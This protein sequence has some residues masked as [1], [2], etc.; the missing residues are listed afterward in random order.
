MSAFQLFDL[1]SPPS[2]GLQRCQP[3]EFKK[4]VSI[5][6]HPWLKK[7]LCGSLRPRRLCIEGFSVWLQLHDFAPLR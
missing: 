3:Y 6:V 7:K 4:T 1:C 2:I 5:H